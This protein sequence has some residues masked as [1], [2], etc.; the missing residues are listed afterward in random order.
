MSNDVCCEAYDGN[1]ADGECV[2]GIIV[3]PRLHEPDGIAK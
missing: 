3:L 2:Q 1:K